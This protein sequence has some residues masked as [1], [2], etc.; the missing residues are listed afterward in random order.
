MGTWG[1]GLYQSDFAK[2]LKADLG[3]WLG[4]PM[5]AAE[6]VAGLQAEKGIGAPPL[7]ADDCVFWL[8]MADQFHRYGLEAP[9]VSERAFRIID[10]GTDIA[11]QAELG[12]SDADQSKRAAVLEALRNKLA[13]PAERPAKRKI[14]KPEPQLLQTGDLFTYPVMDGNPRSEPLGRHAIETYR[15][16][17][18]ALNAFVVLAEARYFHDLFARA[19]IAPLSLYHEGSGITVEDCLGASFLCEV[20]FSYRTFQPLGGWTAMGAKG[21]KLVGAE[22]IGRV[23]IDG[24]AARAVFG[25]ALDPP[26][27]RFMMAFDPLHVNVGFRSSIARGWAWGGVEDT[28]GALVAGSPG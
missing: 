7:T 6:I 13:V 25:E 14:L 27:S 9:E 22:K 17:P 26:P 1:T 20:S 3:E 11:A 15:F 24:A 28:L 2:D 23:E 16:E 21:M 8:V 4:V 18:N 10:E 5:S 19:F 12:L